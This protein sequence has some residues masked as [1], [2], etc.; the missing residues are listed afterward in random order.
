MVGPLNGT[1]RAKVG[2]FDYTYPRVAA[3]TIYLWPERPQYSPY[4]YDPWGPWWGY[5]PYW[6]G[7]YWG[8]STIIVRHPTPPPPPPRAG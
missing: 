2:N 6:G 7:P 1:E 5:G 8:G 3:Q 4:Y